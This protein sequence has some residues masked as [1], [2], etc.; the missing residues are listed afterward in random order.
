M[1]AADIDGDGRADLLSSGGAGFV[2]LS[3]G[4]TTEDGVGTDVIMADDL[5]YVAPGMSVA[6]LGDANGDGLREILAGE[7][8]ATATGSRAAAQAHR[9]GSASPRPAT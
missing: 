6:V 3:F 2:E 9:P 5:D 8:G 4:R 7:Q 1:D